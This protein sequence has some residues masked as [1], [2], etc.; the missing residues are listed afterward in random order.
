MDSLTIDKVLRKNC[1]IYRG[2]FACDELPIIRIRPFVIVV[3]TDPS[4]KPGR[5]WICMYVD[6]DDYGEYFDS[7]GLPPKLVFERYMNN[8]C[9]SWNFNRKQM[10]SLVSRFCGHYCIWYCMNKFR[11]VSL[12]ELVHVISNDTG[13]ND[14]LIH[15]FACK[16]IISV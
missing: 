13:L 11:S 3:N 6:V 14:F 12:N 7:F 10:Q 16:L 1:G 9:M 4:S 2:I 8:T 5:H 15:R